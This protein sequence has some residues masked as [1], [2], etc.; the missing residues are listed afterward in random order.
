MMLGAYVAQELRFSCFF[1]LATCV[2]AV[3]C[4]SSPNF[5]PSDD[6]VPFRDFIRAHQ[7]ASV[8]CQD[9]RTFTAEL[10]LSGR[11]SNEALRG[12]ML[13]GFARPSSLR[14]V[15]LVAF[16]QPAFILTAGR[17]GVLLYLPRDQRVLRGASAIDVLDAIAGVAL[18]P[19]DLQA[20]LTGCAT[21]APRPV[22]GR[23]HRNGWV[24]V[25]LADGATVYLESIDG[26]WR[27]RAAR[28]AGLIVEY[29]RFRGSFPAEVVLRSTRRDIEIT[30][31]LD[32]LE[33]NTEIDPEAFTVV[34]PKNAIPISLD[35]LRAIGLLRAI[36]TGGGP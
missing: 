28:L 9:V 7:E 8:A 20:V 24:A 36:G 29:P 32:Q 10:S 6:G 5:L 35:E 3:S 26:T 33:T 14:L 31:R 2:L 11:V 25:G 34:V 1:V 18:K 4:A 13:S 12:R 15:G 22:N 19:E 30:A 21:A 17:T 16:G 23:L 27:P